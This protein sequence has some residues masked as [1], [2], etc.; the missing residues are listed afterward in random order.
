MRQEV[1]YPTVER[2]DPILLPRTTQVDYVVVAPGQYFNA[3]AQRGIALALEAALRPRGEVV[4]K[5]G[6]DR[7][8][9]KARPADSVGG[10][11][12]FA[13]LDTLKEILKPQKPYVAAGYVMVNAEVP[14]GTYL[15]GLRL[16]GTMRKEEV[17]RVGHMIQVLPSVRQFL[18]APVK[19]A[20][21]HFFAHVE[22]DWRRVA[23]T[24]MLELRAADTS[25]CVTLNQTA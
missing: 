18:T 3:H 9:V 13:V 7:L 25:L 14:P 11:G 10:F 22:G 16:L 4:L 12:T 8:V 24:F 1:R 17:E 15:L 23:T 21:L 2:I 6:G 5:A 20:T 19:D